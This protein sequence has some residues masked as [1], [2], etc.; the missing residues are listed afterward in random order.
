[1]KNRCRLEYLA[2]VR[3]ARICPPPHAYGSRAVKKKKIVVHVVGCFF[4]R[5]FVCLFCRTTTPAR[6]AQI[7]HS[8][9]NILAKIRQK[10]LIRLILEYPLVFYI[11]TCCMNRRHEKYDLVRQ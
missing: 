9:Q 10:N 6:Q 3:R 1:M 8:F 11:R 2:L 4:V 7:L 5:L